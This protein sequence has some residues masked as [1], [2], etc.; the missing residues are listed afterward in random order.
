MKWG[1][2]SLQSR[3]MMTILHKNASDSS[4]EPALFSRGWGGFLLVLVVVSALTFGVATRYS[5][6]STCA[7]ATT[8]S[9]VSVHSQN[10]C[11]RM[12]RDAAVWIISLAPSIFVGKPNRESILLPAAPEL[13]KPFYDRELYNRPPPS[14]LYS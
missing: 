12:D 7:S 5:G 14:Q 3:F 4:R 6:G 11:P 10:T 8:H 9:V 1:Y 2:I 13:I